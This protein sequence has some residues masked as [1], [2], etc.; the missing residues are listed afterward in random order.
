MP[1]RHFYILGTLLLAAWIHYSHRKALPEGTETRPTATEQAAAAS[2]SSSSAPAAAVRAPKTGPAA[3]ASDGFDLSL[4]ARDNVWL[5]LTVDDKPTT[6]ATLLPG[7]SMTVRGLRQITLKI[8]NVAGL[9]V[10]FNGRT[11]AVR[12]TPGRT[13]TLTFTSSGLQ[14]DNPVAR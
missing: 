7:Q 11:V 6:E 9:G 4:Q 1:K 12:G 3:S 2:V 14:T 13:R 10:A 8:G 5:A